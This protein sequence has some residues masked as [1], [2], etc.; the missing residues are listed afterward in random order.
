[1]ERVGPFDERFRFAG[2]RD[3]LIRSKLAGVLTLPV[4]RIFYRYLCREGSATLDPGRRHYIDIRREHI[5]IANILI[6]RGPLADEL[7]GKL[8]VWKA[9]EYAWM[10]AARL[11]PF[12]WGLGW[13]ALRCGLQTNAPAFLKFLTGRQNW[14]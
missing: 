9:C 3:M 7:A 8:N 5:A 12:S 10:A 11:K 1:M 4:N 2:D 13:H 6:N 14:S